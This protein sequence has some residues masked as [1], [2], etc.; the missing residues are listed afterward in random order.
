[1]LNTT[2][3]HVAPCYAN[4]AISCE[5]RLSNAGVYYHTF[6]IKAQLSLGKILRDILLRNERYGY[7]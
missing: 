3:D 5:G 1:M 4:N 2:P 6:Y 7:G